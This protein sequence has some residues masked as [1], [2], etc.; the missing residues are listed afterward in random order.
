MR[1]AEDLSFLDYVYHDRKALRY[2]E[3][4]DIGT[5]MAVAVMAVKYRKICKDIGTDFDATADR[6]YAE[7]GA[8]RWALMTG[9]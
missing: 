6:L 2:L 1:E 7:L 3:T 8:A 5:A 9:T 4:G